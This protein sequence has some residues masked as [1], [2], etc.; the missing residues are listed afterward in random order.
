MN[1]KCSNIRNNKLR[2]HDNDFRNLQLYHP[3]FKPENCNLVSFQ[4]ILSSSN[5]GPEPVWIGSGSSYE[6]SSVP[7]WNQIE[8]VPGYFAVVASLSPQNIL[9]MNI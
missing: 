5:A 2:F 9:N 6:T 8:G 4:A 3:W 1:P 7:D